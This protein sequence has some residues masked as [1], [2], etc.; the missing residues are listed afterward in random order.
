VT[1]RWWTDAP[2]APR[3]FPSPFDE[4]GPH[5]IARRAALELQDE[6]RRGLIAPGVPTDLLHGPMGG[7]MFGVLVV[8][9]A[10][11]RFGFLRAFSAT[12]A[13]TW[14]VE[15]YAPPLFERARRAEVEP[16]GELAVK[17]IH[18]VVTALAEHPLRRDMQDEQRKMQARHAEES[19]GLVRRHRENR[20]ARHAR[21]AGIESNGAA[22]LQALDQESRADKAE[23][24]RL[25]DRHTAE[26]TALEARRGPLE[27]RLR[28]A[29]RLRLWTS[30]RTMQAI[31]DTYRLSSLSGRTSWL[32][33]LWPDAPPAG[34]GDCAGAKLLGAA[35][36]LGL[37]P[38]AMAEFWWGTPPPSGGRVAGAFHPACREKCG[39]LLPFLLHGLE[40]APPRRFLP[41]A[42]VPFPPGL[43]HEDA[44]LVVLE[45]PEGLL[46]VPGRVVAPDAQTLLRQRY[47]GLRLAHR[48]D[49]DTSGLMVAA[50]DEATYVLLQRMFLD[51]R[52]EKRYVALLDGVV[53]GD[54]GLIELPM[55]GDPA[56]RPRQVVDPIEGK[57]SATRWE[58]LERHGPRTL[59]ALWPLTGRTHQLRVHAAHPAG[60]NAPVVGDRLYGREGAR[61]MLHAEALAFAHPMTGERLTFERPALREPPPDV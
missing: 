27:R 13:G 2:E 33:D 26:R 22:A 55:R 53:P 51:R 7:K 25:E 38:V 50:R 23:R 9:D 58:V 59:V 39:P 4:L 24:R 45:K 31:F 5:P 30:R 57:P 49:M 52:I 43:I 10:S 29:E 36:R 47:P 20:A 3:V 46:S 34:A 40:V 1:V 61:L 12:L 18:A 54:A 21:R 14:D 19:E 42:V 32:R 56:D 28:A 11:G 60:L 16:A 44:H 8:R 15:G 35:T 48:L 41:P 37:V 17:R 6:L